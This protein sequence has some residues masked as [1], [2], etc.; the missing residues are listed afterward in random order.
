MNL[1]RAARTAINNPGMPG[2]YGRYLILRS[3]GMGGPYIRVGSDARVGRKW[4]N[5]SEYWSYRGPGHGPGPSLPSAVKSL[6]ASSQARASG[7]AVAIDAGANIGLFTAAFAASG[8]SEV[9]AFEPVP[10][11]F[12][13]LADNV[14]INH[15]KSKVL[16]N[17]MGLGDQER[18]LNIRYD[19][20]SPATAHMVSEATSDTCPVQITT[21]DKYAELNGIQRIDF[22]KIDT[23]GYETAVLL[24]SESL[25]NE[26]R[27]S[28]ILLE[29]CPEL[30]VRAGSSPDRLWQ[31]IKDMGYVLHPISLAPKTD[32][33]LTLAELKSNP[34]DNLIAVPS[35]APM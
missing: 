28:L 23:E 3:L 11:T 4:T 8:F 27:V 19:W 22:L 16:L 15:F 10:A 1:I 25:L 21:L 7:R 26:K 29:W 17:P 6:I 31:L 20:K 14:A 5:F 13:R 24:G 9:H 34:W 18:V 33:P 2:A 30:L 35:E 32:R 12:E